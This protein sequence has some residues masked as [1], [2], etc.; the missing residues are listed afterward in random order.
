MTLVM[1]IEK[2]FVRRIMLQQTAKA[3]QAMMAQAPGKRP[4]RKV[5]FCSIQ[6]QLRPVLSVLKIQ[7]TFGTLLGSLQLSRFLGLQERLSRHSRK[8]VSRN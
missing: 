2:L 4:G 1:D 7:P 5:L 8:T 6:K 3:L